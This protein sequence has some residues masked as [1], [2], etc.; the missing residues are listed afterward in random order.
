M[1]SFC[2]IFTLIALFISSFHSVFALEQADQ[3]AIENVIKGYTQAWNQRG[4]VGFADN[5]T[6]DASFV[7][8]LG[9]VFS[10]K[11]EIEDRHVKILETFLKDSI[12]QIQSTELREI[13]PG[14][15]IALVRWELLGNFSFHPD[16]KKTLD[17]RKGVF[18]QVFINSDHKWEITASQNTLIT[19]IN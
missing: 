15:V 8:I 7:N 1:N 2:K 13:Q 12:L 6:E 19:T 14:V 17:I 18:T 9:M 5:F 4:C 11:T 10:G 3:L 16:A